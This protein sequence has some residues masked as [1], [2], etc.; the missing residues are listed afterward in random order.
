MLELELDAVPNFIRFEQN[1]I[2]VMW[3]F[4][5]ALGCKFHGTGFPIGEEY[6]KGHVL[7]ESPN[8]DGFVMA[9]V[10]SRTFEHTGHSVVMDLNGVVVHDPN[11]NKAWQDI[12]ILES[13]DLKHW[14]MIE[15]ER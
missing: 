9:S 11:P 7:S 10:P 2:K 8:I 13:G 5:G 4:L 14:L 1:Y 15:K 3:G 12:N 6:P